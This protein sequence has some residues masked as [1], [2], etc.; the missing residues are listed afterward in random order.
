MI[1][2]SS[3]SDLDKVI[4]VGVNPSSFSTKDLNN[5][6]HYEAAY[7]DFILDIIK[8][9]YFSTSL[10]LNKEISIGTPESFKVLVCE[11][12]ALCLDIGL[13]RQK[14]EFSSPNQKMLDFFIKIFLDNHTIIPRAIYF[15]ISNSYFK[16]F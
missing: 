12:Q 4:P 1:N 14:N 13:F 2:Q 3:L 6:T 15:T 7:H 10:I 5:Y 8:Q 9:Q 16:G 11:L